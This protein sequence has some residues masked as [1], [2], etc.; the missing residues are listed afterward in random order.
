MWSRDNVCVAAQHLVHSEGSARAVA[1]LCNGQGG[2][3]PEDMSGKDEESMRR[4]HPRE[5][6]ILVMS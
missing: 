6:R 4:H 2:S 1:L 3:S 5:V